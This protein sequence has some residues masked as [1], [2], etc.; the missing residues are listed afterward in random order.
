MSLADDVEKVA[1]EAR[2]R[3]QAQVDDLSEDRAVEQLA[4]TIVADFD[5]AVEGLRFLADRIEALERATRAG[6]GS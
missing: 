4:V 3:R 2:D 5:G 6:Q 1:L